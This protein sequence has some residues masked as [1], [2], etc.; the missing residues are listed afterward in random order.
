MKA[1]RKAIVFLGIAAV[2]LGIPSTAAL[3]NDDTQAPLAITLVAG[4][5]LISPSTR[6]A[7]QP[8]VKFRGSVVVAVCPVSFHHVSERVSN[9]VFRDCRSNLQSLCLL[10][11]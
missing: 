11:C 3:E 10:R 4:P 9:F 1:V 2:L 5:A 7:V 6:G 8:R